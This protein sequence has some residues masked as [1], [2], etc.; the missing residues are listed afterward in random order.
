MSAQKSQIKQTTY[1][2]E[3]YWKYESV[4]SLNNT[5]FKF[6]TDLLSRDGKFAKDGKWISFFEEDSSKVASIFEVKNGKLNGKSTQFYFNG[7]KQSEY[8][9]LDGEQNGYERYWNKKGILVLEYQHK[10]KDYLNFQS[11]VRNGEWKDW[12]DNGTLIRIRNFQDDELH[13]R[14]LKFLENGQLEK[15][16]FY[17]KGVK[18]NN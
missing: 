16:E 14:Q 15:E 17:I 18:T 7:G 13:G 9:F 2:D 3:N 8:E 4:D 12:N 1:N 10:Y 11:S 5:P 6:P